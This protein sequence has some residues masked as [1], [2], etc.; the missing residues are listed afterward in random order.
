MEGLLP[1][2]TTTAVGQTITLTPD[3]TD[4]LR[5]TTP[6][7]RQIDWAAHRR[8]VKTR[9]GTVNY[10]DIGEGDPACVLLHGHAA[11]STGWKRCP[12]WPSITESSPS[13]CPDSAGQSCCRNRRGRWM[14]WPPP[15]TSSPICSPLG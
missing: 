7:W 1:A 5:S 11:G 14:I 10:V 2:T 9:N 12:P 13:T 3:P 8:Q 4:Y 6:D 15:L